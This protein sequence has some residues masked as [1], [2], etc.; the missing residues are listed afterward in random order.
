MEEAKEEPKEEI[1]Q[2]NQEKEKE[3]EEFD[4]NTLYIL[5]Y[6]PLKEEISHQGNSDQISFDI[7]KYEIKATSNLT[8]KE[9]KDQLANNYNI[10]FDEF[11][12]YSKDED[13]SEN[14]D[15]KLLDTIF[16]TNEKKELYLYHKSEL[17]EIEVEYR[18]SYY[19]VKIHDSMSLRNIRDMLVK[20][21]PLKQHK[22]VILNLIVDGINTY[23][24]KEA[25]FYNLR[26][27]NTIKLDSS[28]RKG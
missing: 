22:I 19:K 2:I 15:D 9:I 11:S 20:K 28:T 25:A 16:S 26:K 3:N 23:G 5:L 7:K 21:Y 6:N 1:N 8:L 14:C 13:L 27:A 4:I 18:F 12:L 24:E 17:Y 10:S